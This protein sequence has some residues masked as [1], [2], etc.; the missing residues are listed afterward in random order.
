MTKGD[1][2]LIIGGGIVGGAAAYYLAKQ[3]CSVTL[4]EKSSLFR[5][6]W[7]IP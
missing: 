5:K 6:R 1:E 7:F 3:G 4:L 2:I